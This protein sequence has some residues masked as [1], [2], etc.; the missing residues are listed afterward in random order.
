MIKVSEYLRLDKLDCEASPSEIARTT[1]PTPLAKAETGE[2][3]LPMRKLPA[4]QQNYSNSFKSSANNNTGESPKFYLSKS[5]KPLNISTGRPFSPDF[6]KFNNND[7]KSTDESPNMKKS[8]ANSKN[9]SR[10][11]AKRI[12]TMLIQEL[13]DFELTFH[14]NDKGSQSPHELQLPTS[15]A[16]AVD[17]T[18]S[19]KKP[20]GRRIKRTSKNQEKNDSNRDQDLKSLLQE[21]T[22]DDNTSEISKTNSREDSFG[23][24]YSY[25]KN[26]QKSFKYKVT[27]KAIQRT[28]SQQIVH[29]LLEAAAEIGI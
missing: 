10:S 26:P 13:D 24:R 28:G 21:L 16:K 15:P 8:A 4:F 14:K 29:E 22:A 1:T 18:E 19:V 20:T 25:M 7:S 12:P 11:E 6:S 3:P 27:K 9:V 2:S 17:F 5:P 23:E